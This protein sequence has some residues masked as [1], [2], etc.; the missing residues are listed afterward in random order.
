MQKIHMISRLV[1]TLELNS[2]TPGNHARILTREQVEPGLLV[3]GFHI[4]ASVI[5]ESPDDLLPIIDTWINELQ[6]M[7]AEVMRGTPRTL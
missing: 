2:Q 6:V 5:G 7:R 4:E 3:K 1:S